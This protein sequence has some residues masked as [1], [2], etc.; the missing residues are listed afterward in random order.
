[1]VHQA[2]LKVVKAAHPAPP[3]L[4]M[5]KKKNQFYLIRELLKTL[6]QLSTCKINLQNPVRTK[7]IR[8]IKKGKRN[9]RALNGVKRRLTRILMIL[10]KIFTVKI[11]NIAALKPTE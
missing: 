7:K 5:R 10:M 3:V 9:L 11:W 2:A 4:T 6:N 8:K 1:M